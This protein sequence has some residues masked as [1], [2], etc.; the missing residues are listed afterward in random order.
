MRKSIRSA[1]WL[2]LLPITACLL[3]TACLAQP[4]PVKH[5]FGLTVEP[6]EA[7]LPPPANNRR[8]L[9]V[10][11]VTAA[12]GYDN[13]GLVYKIGSDQYETDFYNEFMA[14]PARLLADQTAQYLD[15][16][17]R[18]VRVVKSPGLTLASFGLE[19]YLAHIY[20]DFTTSPPQAEL[21][22]RF[23]FNDLRGRSPRVIFDRVYQARSPITGEKP[24]DVAAALNAALAT[25]LS[26]L[27]LDI[28]QKRI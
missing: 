20:G 19:T 10:G 23:T 15:R 14:P 7:A 22:I 5:L 6:A 24:A 9:L 25:I 28:E 4:H 21:A 18:R 13:R 27:N 8:T 12:A 26:E 17:S 16:A 11:A 3:L 1:G 2:V